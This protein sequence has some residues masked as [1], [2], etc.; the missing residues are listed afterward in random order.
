MPI[1]TSVHNSTFHDKTAA[2]L[3][4]EFNIANLPICRMNFL[5]PFPEPETAKPE[6]RS[7]GT[8]K[9]C[10]IKKKYFFVRFVHI[11]SMIQSV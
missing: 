3:E 10:S 4:T 6:P 5:N 2:I 7:P 9:L 11:E 8:C 1:D